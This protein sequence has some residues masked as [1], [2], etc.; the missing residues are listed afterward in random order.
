MHSQVG[1][2]EI[3]QKKESSQIGI[4]IYPIEKLEERIVFSIHLRVLPPIRIPKV[5][6]H[7]AL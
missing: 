5:H 2:G 1:T 4:E 7:L 3:N 6:V